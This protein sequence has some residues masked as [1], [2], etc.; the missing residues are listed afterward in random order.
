MPASLELEATW[1]LIERSIGRKLR[2][3]EKVRDWIKIGSALDEAK[4]DLTDAIKAEQR[5]AVRRTVLTGK[6]PVRLRF[7][8]AMSKPLDRL[9]LLGQT[10]ALAEL[11][12]AG[13]DTS[14]RQLVAQLTPGPEGAWEYVRSELGHLSEKI[15]GH[16]VSLDVSGAAQAAVFDALYNVAGSRGIASKVV[17]TALDGGM[18]QTFSEFSDI[19]SSWERTGA[20]DGNM[21]DQC[22][23]HDGEEYATWEE[24]MDSLPDGGPDPECAGGGS[25]R[26]GLVPVPA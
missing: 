18:A 26:C 25:C 13:Y 2:E 23:A 6:K 5:R 15:E 8:D 22:E 14:S 17:T 7:T 9:R 21:C 16:R 24:A 20:G 4:E 11:R 1:P 12:R 3:A 19:V 10:E